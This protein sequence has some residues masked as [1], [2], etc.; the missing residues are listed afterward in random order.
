MMHPEFSFFNFIF[1]RKFT[2]WIAMLIRDP[3]FKSLAMLP[4]F[5]AYKTESKDSFT[6]V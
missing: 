5:Y 4:W 2:N 1:F 6:S 3:Y